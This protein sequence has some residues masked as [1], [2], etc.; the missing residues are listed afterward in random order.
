MSADEH[1]HDRRVHHA[2]A[3][4]DGLLLGCFMVSACTF[5]TLLWH[6]ASPTRA[7]LGTGIGARV[8][9]GL[10]MGLTSAALVHSAWGRRSGAHMNPA[11]TLTMV[12]L[13]RMAPRDGFA[14]VAAQFTGG[15]LGVL[16]SWLLL[17]DRLAHPDVRFVVTQPGMPGVTVAFLAELAM[18]AGLMTLVLETSA[19]PRWS[20]W[21]GRMAA[22]C[23][24]TFIAL[25]SPL[26]G[27]SLNPARTVSSALWGRDLTAIWIYFV[28]PMLGMTAAALAHVAR[29]RRTDASCGKLVHA[30]PCLFC[31]Y[32]ASRS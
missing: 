11:F 3:A 25:E 6:P 21:T 10:L 7:L 18:A 1:R 28:A 29:H 24:A 17:G 9:M 16:L 12:G 20:R 15:S 30:E 26:S 32:I 14:Y 8:P 13:G 23:V 22:A 4:I 31:E 27:M 2:E 5:G 19:S